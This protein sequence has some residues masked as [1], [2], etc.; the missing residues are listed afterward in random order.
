M[1][2]YFSLVLLLSCLFTLSFSQKKKENKEEKKDDLSSI[3]SGLKFRHIG[4]AFMSG[5]ISDIV[6]HPDHQNTWYVTAG[7]G[8]VWKTNN[9]G[10]TWSSL[11]DG[12]KS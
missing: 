2:K 11:F 6:I 12:Q 5:R 4:P 8:G 3:F 1:K 10:N 9:A 7:S